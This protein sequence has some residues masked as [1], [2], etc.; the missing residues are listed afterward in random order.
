MQS[1]VQAAAFLFDQIGAMQNSYPKTSFAADHIDRQKPEH[2]N[3]VKLLLEKLGSYDQDYLVGFVIWI[4]SNFKGLGVDH[5]GYKRARA[6]GTPQGPEGLGLLV[7]WAEDYARVAQ[8]GQG[9][10]A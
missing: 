6:P 8:G 9:A 10:G 3:L 5:R 1:K 4:S 7:K 2:R